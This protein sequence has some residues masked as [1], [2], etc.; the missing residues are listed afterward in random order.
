MVLPRCLNDARDDG[1]VVGAKLYSLIASCM[2]L[3]SY[4]CVAVQ[5]KI[6]SLLRRD[7]PCSM[8]TLEMPPVKKEPP[9][10][11]FSCGSGVREDDNAAEDFPRS[12]HLPLSSTATPVYAEVD[13]ELEDIPQTSRATVFT[14][15]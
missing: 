6:C 11:V 2:R 7:A 9:I 15:V 14:K 12:F 10:E 3:F 1:S 8:S 5:T 4:K 13:T